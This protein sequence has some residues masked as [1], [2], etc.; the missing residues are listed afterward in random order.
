MMS[1]FL[2]EEIP[3]LK[4]FVKD[5]MVGYLKEADGYLRARF[6]TDTEFDD[7]RDHIAKGLKE[8]DKDVDLLMDSNKRLKEELKETKKQLERHEEMFMILMDLVKTLG[9]KPPT[10]PV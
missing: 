9:P 1:R 5:P 4:Q 3:G 2:H 8:T 6:V 7:Y 10:P